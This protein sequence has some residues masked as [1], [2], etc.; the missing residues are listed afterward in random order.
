MT[1]PAPV[2]ETSPA[3]SAHLTIEQSVIQRMATNSTSCKAWCITLVSAILVVVADKNKPNLA[4]LALL[5]TVL[6][7]ALDG[8]YLG[9]EKM[10]RN[11]YK[12]FLNKLHEK[13]IMPDDLFVIKPRGEQFEIFL[14]AL[15]SFSV[16][17]FYACLIAMII[18]VRWIVI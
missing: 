7:F 6:F 13:R 8:Y 15:V 12:D 9:L 10:F 2:S 17:P 11:S 3:V 4:F 1:D 18:L 5:P 14:T 16:L